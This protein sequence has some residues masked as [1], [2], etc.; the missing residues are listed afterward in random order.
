MTCSRKNVLSLPGIEPAAKLYTD[1]A[2][3][4]PN[5]I[6]RPIIYGSYKRLAIFTE[7]LEGKLSFLRYFWN[8]MPFAFTFL[9][10]TGYTRSDKQTLGLVYTG[11]R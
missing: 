6:I 5:S 4:A 8:L 2:I 3:L 1:S 7:A 10:Y 11:K 9:A